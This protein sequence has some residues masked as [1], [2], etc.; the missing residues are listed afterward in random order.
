M[1]LHTQCPRDENEREHQTDQHRPG[2]FAREQVPTQKAYCRLKH[3][4]AQ[5]NAWIQIGVQQIREQV[6]K[7]EYR[8][9]DNDY[10]VNQ[11]QIAILN[12]TL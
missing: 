12:S 3:Y 9:H 8:N 10:R 2:V 7:H 4:S 1:R 5:A 11:W 6:G